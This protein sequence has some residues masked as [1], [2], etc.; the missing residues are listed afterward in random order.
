MILGIS[1]TKIRRDNAKLRNEGLLPTMLVF[2][3][4][5]SELPIDL[6][7]RHIDFS[8]KASSTRRAPLGRV[9]F[10]CLG[11]QR[12]D[13]SCGARQVVSFDRG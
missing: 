8:T 3:A 13:L 10:V 6:E 9:I 4:A 2:G 1:Y 5:L 11:L 7:I 12:R